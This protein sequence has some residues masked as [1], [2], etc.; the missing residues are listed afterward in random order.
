[1]ADIIATTCLMTSSISLFRTTPSDRDVS[2]A[3]N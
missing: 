1:M 3:L 2:R